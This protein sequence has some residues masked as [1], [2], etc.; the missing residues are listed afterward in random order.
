MIIHVLPGDAYVDTFRETGIEGD[1]AIFRECLIEGDVT[2]ENL[3]DMFT[4]REAFLSAAY[5]DPAKSYQEFVVNEIEKFA[6]AKASDEVNLWFEYELFCS[7]NYWFCLSLLANS[8]ADIYRV[9]PS[10][11]DD[12]TKWRGFGKLDAQE[13]IEC[14]N[15]RIRLKKA[16]LELGRDLWNAYRSKNIEQ[17]L[18]LGT[19]ASPAFPYLIDVV[20]AEEVID[21][22]PKRILRELVGEGTTDFGEVFP[23][24]ARR[25]GVYGLGDVQVKRIFDE[26]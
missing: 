9:A 11:R 15:H 6:H 5:P 1:V 10:V 24:F 23:L 26:L 12:S 16:D 20:E 19:N 3:Q 13:L 21:S 4:S 22:E 18:R 7:V 17:L 25:A 8:N 2:G 14:W